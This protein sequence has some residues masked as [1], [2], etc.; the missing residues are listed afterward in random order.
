MHQL[1]SDKEITII[2]IIH[3]FDDSYDRDNCLLGIEKC[4]GKKKCFMHDQWIK[5][6]ET[7]FQMYENTTLCDILHKGEKL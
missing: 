5:S 4:D 6:K 7:L 2:E 3:L 1:K